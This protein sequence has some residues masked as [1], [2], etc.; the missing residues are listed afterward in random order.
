VIG[1]ALSA[2][3]GEPQRVLAHPRG[4]N[5]SATGGS[6][7]AES[8][9]AEIHAAKKPF[10]V[11]ILSKPDGTPFYVGAG[12]GKRILAHEKQA[13]GNGKS[14]K[15]STI[16]K[17]WRD[18]GEVVRAFDSWHDTEITAFDREIELIDF[19]GRRDIKTGPLTNETGGGERGDFG[20]DVV[21]RRTIAIRASRKTPEY[22]K[23]LSSF[24]E[25]QLHR[26]STEEARRLHSEINKQWLK[27][28][29]E[30][31]EEI[32]RKQRESMR[33]P[34]MRSQCSDREKKKSSPEHSRL[35][36]ERMKKWTLEHP[37]LA[38]VYKKKRAAAF[39]NDRIR[40][41]SRARI[42]KW[43]RNP[44]KFLL[45]K[46]KRAKTL[47]DPEFRKAHSARMLEWNRSNPDK[48]AAATK[49]RIE[50]MQERKSLRA[51][52]LDLVSKYHLQLAVPH[53]RSGI[54][55]WQSCY[56]D[57]TELLKKE[58]TSCRQ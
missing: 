29:P 23:W 33:T 41:A 15:L 47:Q 36:S 7:M 39:Q 27:D 46:A 35:L 26:F 16:R 19:V 34:E 13:R 43:L 53:P 32:F 56:S 44:E 18:G 3:I 1:Q 5:Q 31:A 14:H 37:E 22:Q 28:N 42:N 51:K 54:A 10:Y 12:K 11:Y 8:I 9:L 38:E 20:P 4:S 40:E 17:I 6:V 2:T 45:A 25:K 30:L 24:R 48:V 52:C 58:T 50:M 21:R 49:A 57:I 55:A